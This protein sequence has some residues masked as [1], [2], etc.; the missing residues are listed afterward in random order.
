MPEYQ[1][2]GSSVKVVEHDLVPM[3]DQDFKVLQ[4][5][6]DYKS[7]SVR[8]D[9][10]LTLSHSIKWTPEIMIKAAESQGFKCMKIFW[11]TSN[12]VPIYVF[13]AMPISH[14]NQFQAA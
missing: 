14:Y 8:K 3:C 5:S 9:Q 2:E 12:R 1:I 6:G 7:A 11:D 10:R 4:C 13:K